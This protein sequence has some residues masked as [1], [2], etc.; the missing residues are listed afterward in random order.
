MIKG[1]VLVAGDLSE[2]TEGSLRAPVAFSS[3]NGYLDICGGLVARVYAIVERNRCSVEISQE[4][5]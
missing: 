3:S 5:R 1:G 4:I 2:G